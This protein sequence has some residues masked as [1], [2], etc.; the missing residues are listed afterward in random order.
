M[1][2]IETSGK[3]MRMSF[4][5]LKAVCVVSA[6]VTGLPLISSQA[7]VITDFD[8]WVQSSDWN[9][10]ILGDV[11]DYS[12]S[13][14][15]Q[16]D[17]EGSV[18]IKGNLQGTGG[19][20]PSL[21]IGAKLATQ[22]G[23]DA[24]QTTLVVGGN[25]TNRNNQISGSVWV[26]GNAA[27]GGGPEFGGG[28]SVTGNLTAG[29]DLTF[30]ASNS[31]GQIG[32]ALGAGAMTHVG[33]VAE[34]GRSSNVFGTL[35]GND[36]V[37][38][39]GDGMGDTVA[40]ITQNGGVLTDI[41]PPSGSFR[42]DHYNGGGDFDPYLNGKALSAGP[43][44]LPASPIDF[45]LITTGLEQDSTD[46]ALLNSNASWLVDDGSREGSVAIDGTI[47]VVPSSAGSRT[48]TVLD[49]AGSSTASG[50]AVIFN[51]NTNPFDDTLSFDPADIWKNG[52]FI[53]AD[54]DTSIIINISGSSH[55]I[56]DF[57]F[58]YSPV[59]SYENVIFNFFDATEIFLGMADNSSGIGFKG[60]IFAPLAHVFFYNGLLEGNLVAA[61]LTGNGQ[62]NWM[63]GQG[64][65]VPEPG[66]LWLLLVGG[67]AVWIF[68]GQRL[69]VSRLGVDTSVSD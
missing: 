2:C 45:D 29:G 31:G 53:D 10:L 36:T 67:L 35:H 63:H 68:K 27:L 11:T 8:A 20:I 59:L 40:I 56:T 23:F 32:Q 22:S 28:F 9:A 49:A 26:G 21:T 41:A 58:E 14:V 65:G 1:V 50:E 55:T 37:I 18:A 62:I 5:P 6:L 69:A 46:M 38:V 42:H 19:A 61:G 30:N 4:V 17:I 16:T 66:I 12:N 24:S 64:Q 33:G 51:L 44:S 60:N 52:F 54:E 57:L 47:S 43:A 15:D 3:S 48:G 7:A 25:L 39:H 34:L 13:G